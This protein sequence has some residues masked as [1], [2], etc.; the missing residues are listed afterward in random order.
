MPALALASNS[1]ALALTGGAALDTPGDFSN[2]GALTL[3]G[4]LNVGGNFTQSAAGT[5]NEQLGGSPASGQFGQLVAAGAAT[6]AGNF[7]LSLV[8]SFTP[9][10]GQ[11]Y[12]VLQY[13]SSS[14]SFTAITGLVPGM[15]ANQTATEFDLDV[16]AAPTNLGLASVTAPTAAID[17]QSIAIQ[18]QV[19]NQ[20]AVNAH[21]GWL[22][23]VYLSATPSITASSILLGSVTHAGGLT[24]GN[25][26]NG[27]LT[28]AVPAL[29]PGNYYVLVLADSHYNV[30]DSDRS[31]NTL[32]ATT[33]QLAVSV[34]GL[35]LGTP[36][37]GAFTAANQDQYYQVTVPAGGSLVVTLTSSAGS[38]ATALYV[39]QG[40]RRRSIT[41]NSQPRRTS[42]INR[43]PC[44]MSRA[45]CIIS[46]FTASP[47]PPQRRTIR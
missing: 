11:S 33:G 31:N 5:L 7:N 13:A 17:G 30:A 19:N 12:P 21:G 3:G 2:S 45:A 18:W 32:A 26:Y 28:A 16:A 8:N 43:S 40:A 39:S 24:A 25:S 1:G 46:W 34:P 38:G 22:D 44:R 20:G 29:A 42:R 14:G 35:T 41:I 6:L 10:V 15:T 23:S 4:A 9:V 37:N 36:V 27:S 47:A